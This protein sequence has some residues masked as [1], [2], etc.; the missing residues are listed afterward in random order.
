MRPVFILLI[1]QNI[2]LIVVFE[3]CK[4]ENLFELE[5]NPLFP[6]ISGQLMNQMLHISSIYHIPRLAR[7]EA[8]PSA[9]E[10]CN[11]PV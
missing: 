3:I 9:L 7:E 4:K 2:G 1:S 8:N 5:D 11:S 6:I 10:F